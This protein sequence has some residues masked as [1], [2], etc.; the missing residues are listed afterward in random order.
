MAALT[1][2]VHKGIYPPM[3][4]QPVPIATPQFD[5]LAD[6]IPAFISDAKLLKESLRT[7]IFVSGAP[8]LSD[9]RASYIL[10]NEGE[11]V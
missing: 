1:I 9:G 2:D 6:D 10:R 8:S 7:T 3:T 11:L 5:Q 4:F